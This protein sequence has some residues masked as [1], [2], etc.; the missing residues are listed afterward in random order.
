L[1]RILLGYKGRSEDG[2]LTTLA[3][4]PDGRELVVA[5][6]EPAGHC[7]R[8]YQTADFPVQDRIVRRLAVPPRHSVNRLAL[9]DDR[10]SR[11][12][13][14]FNKTSRVWDWRTKTEVGVD[15][16]TGDCLALAFPGPGPIAIVFDEQ[17]GPKLWSAVHGKS[18]ARLTPAERAT[19]ADVETLARLQA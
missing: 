4:S 5:A 14:E 9:S 12:T 19:V 13:S 10:R 6:A 7:L 11:V 3:F 17:Q 1:E 15:A 16:I 8:V 2:D 18:L